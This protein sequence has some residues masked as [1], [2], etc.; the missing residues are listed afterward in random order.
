MYHITIRLV[1]GRD[2]KTWYQ[3]VG[4]EQ[5]VDVCEETA[6]KN[7]FTRGWGQKEIVSNEGSHHL[8][9]TR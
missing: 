6:E 7:I 5:F 4:K 2:C 3:T 9:A 8:Y 1:V